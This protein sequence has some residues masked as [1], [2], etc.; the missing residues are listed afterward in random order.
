MRDEHKIIMSSYH[1]MPNTD[2]SQLGRDD[3]MYSVN[4]DVEQMLYMMG[5]VFGQIEYKYRI[6][7]ERTNIVPVEEKKEE[8]NKLVDHSNEEFIRNGIL[9]A[10]MD[11]KEGF[12]AQDYHNIEKYENNNIGRE[13]VGAKAT[14]H[15]MTVLTN[16]INCTGRV[17][18]RENVPYYCLL[19]YKNGKEFIGY[20]T[21]MLLQLLIACRDEGNEKAEKVIDILNNDFDS[22]Q[23]CYVRAEN[24]LEGLKRQNTI[25]QR[26]YEE[27]FLI[28]SYD[29][30]NDWI[31]KHQMILEEGD[32][33]EFIF[34]RNKEYGSK[35]NMRFANNLL[36]HIV[37]I[38]RLI[39]HMEPGSIKWEEKLQEKDGL[40]DFRCLDDLVKEL[41]ES[42]Y[43]PS[44]DKNGWIERYIGSL[45]MVV[46]EMCSCM[47]A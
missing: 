29:I 36:W 41:E 10:N 40:S 9:A 17:N 45:S 24:F 38:S 28:G 8:Y 12:S 32:I 30:L 11:G 1:K 46:D 37:Q 35:A 42:S 23:Q 43:N 2:P 44:F 20:L 47:A 25:A 18:K 34:Q 33:W 3:Y 16:N 13:K 7:S 22:M 6:N 39:L 14:L 27:E 19:T 31:L 5:G 21:A 26:N 15:F 4:I